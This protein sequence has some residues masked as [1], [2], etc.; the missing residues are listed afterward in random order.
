MKVPPI[1]M[2]MEVLSCKC[3]FHVKYIVDPI[4]EPELMISNGKK[5]DLIKYFY[6]YW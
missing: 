6:F 3:K 2:D 5:V 1:E 4:K